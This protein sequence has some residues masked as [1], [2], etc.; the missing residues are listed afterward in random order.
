LLFFNR[1]SPRTDLVIQGGRLVLR[2]PLLTDHADWASLRNASRDFLQPWEPL[3]P[4]DDLTLAAFR[5]RIRRYDQ[6]MR[7]DASYPFFL[8][9]AEDGLLMG[10]LNLT[11]VRRGAAAMASLGYWMGASHAGK[12]HMKEAVRMVTEFA[13]L[14]LG[15][16]RIEAACLPENAASL[17]LL[18][19]NGYE[20]EGFARQYLNING[21]WRD[22]VLLAKVTTP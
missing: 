20:R 9:D 4:E 19:A 7:D 8:L 16:L 14:R 2:P 13:R 17:R 15:L 6:E 11:N 3:W 22:H 18:E 5:R 21:Q 10:G 12:G 1:P